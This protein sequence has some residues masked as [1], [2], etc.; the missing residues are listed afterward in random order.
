MERRVE[1][2]AYVVLMRDGVPR[3][4]DPVIYFITIS[5]CPL[6]TEFVSVADLSECLVIRSVGR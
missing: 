2:D 5:F 6:V 1:R 3:C 4:S